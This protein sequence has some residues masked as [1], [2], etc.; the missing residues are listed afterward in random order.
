MPLAGIRY[1]VKTIQ[2]ARADSQGL[3]VKVE[4]ATKKHLDALCRVEA[5]EG[6]SDSA[7]H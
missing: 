1:D 2:S 4:V 7:R 6:V 3:T 5:A